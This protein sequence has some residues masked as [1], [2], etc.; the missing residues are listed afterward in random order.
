MIGEAEIP[1]SFLLIVDQRLVFDSKKVLKIWN[2]HD[3][4]LVVILRE[5]LASP[6]ERE[7]ASGAAKRGSATIRF[8]GNWKS[9][10]L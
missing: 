2:L 9:G 4:C 8:H 10:Y 3:Y 6:E 7:F 5:R 1:L